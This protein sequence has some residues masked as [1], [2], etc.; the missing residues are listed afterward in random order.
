M[1]AGIQPCIASPHLLDVE[2]PFVKIGTHEIG[3]LEFATLRRLQRSGSIHNT[4]IKN[5]ITCGRLVRA[6]SDWLFLHANSIALLVEFDDAVPAGVIDAVAED[7]RTLR[8][9]ARTREQLVRSAPKNRLPPRISA[10]G[11][12]R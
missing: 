5:N 9:G 6:W 7:R 11:L 1:G 12:R 8:P 3:D 2:S 4:V 10:T